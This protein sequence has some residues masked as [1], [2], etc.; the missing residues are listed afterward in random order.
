ML[1][2]NTIAHKANHNKIHIC[3]SVTRAVDD[4]TYAAVV[5][6]IEGSK[7]EEARVAGRTIECKEG[8]EA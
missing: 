5:R 8:G 7:K 4:C 1:K 3:T 2:E 6:M